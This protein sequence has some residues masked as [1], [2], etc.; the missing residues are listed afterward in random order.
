M[1][2]RIK[3]RV[4]S[5]LRN[6]AL[7]GLGIFAISAFSLIAAYIAQYGFDLQPCV[8]CLYQRP[9]YYIAGLLGLVAVFVSGKSLK[10]SSAMI[11]LAGLSFLTG[12]VIASYHTGVE[13]HWWASFLEGCKVSF[14]G[15]TSDLLSIIQ[16][17]SAVP[18]DEIPWSDPIFGL[19]MANYNAIASLGYAIISIT[20]S[21][22]IVRRANGF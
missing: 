17:S 15:D 11:F 21:I 6:P 20:S 19:S 7:V 5:A 8:L 9:P 3:N 14:D 12:S 13:L 1:M 18:C 4:L 16:S 10:V 22:L 2:A